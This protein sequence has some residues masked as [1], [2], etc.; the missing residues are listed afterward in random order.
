VNRYTIQ[1]RPLA[2]TR[3]KAS[4]L[5]ETGSVLAAG[6]GN[7]ETSAIL[8]AAKQLAGVR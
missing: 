5:D 7:D 8:T 3:W 6:I 2:D 4:I 1:T